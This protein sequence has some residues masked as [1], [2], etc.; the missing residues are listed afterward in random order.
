MSSNFK[1][2][3]QL[4]DNLKKYNLP[5]TKSVKTPKLREEY[6]KNY[7]KTSFFISNIKYTCPTFKEKIKAVLNEL[8]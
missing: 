5:L 4:L 7:A 1:I 3:K 8:K 2:S 6:L